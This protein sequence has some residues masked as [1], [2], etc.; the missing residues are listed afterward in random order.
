MGLGVIRRQTLVVHRLWP[1]LIIAK[2][3]K[4]IALRAPEINRI[5]AILTPNIAKKYNI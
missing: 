1:L 4:K 5:G 3:L 2:K